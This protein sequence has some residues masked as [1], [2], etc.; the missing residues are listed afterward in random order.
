M[1]WEVTIITDGHSF[2]Y[3]SNQQ[4][5]DIA[6]AVTMRKFCIEYPEVDMNKLQILDVQVREIT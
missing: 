1:K 3:K 5:R 2:T 4:N 6:I